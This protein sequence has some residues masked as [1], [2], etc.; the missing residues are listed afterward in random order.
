VAVT[1][2]DVIPRVLPPNWRM[3]DRSLDGGAFRCSDGLGVIL[4]L[5]V[6]LDE[7]LWLHVSMSRARQLPSWED[8]RRVKLLFIGRERTAYQV[9]PPESRYV[10]IHPFCLH[11]WTCLDGD[12]TPDFTRGGSSL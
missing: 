9:L 2:D 12:V 10:N 7:K 11:L 3:V 6:E 5:A 4:S 1:V 8:I